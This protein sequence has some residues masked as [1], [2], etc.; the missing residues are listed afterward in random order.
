MLCKLLGDLDSNRYTHRVV[1]LIAPGPLAGRLEALGVSVDSLH[2]RKHP[3]S[4]GALARLRRITR[5]SDAD[6]VHGWMYHGNAGAWWAARGRGMRLIYTIR[7]ALTDIGREKRTT[8]ALIRFG[9]WSSRSADSVLYNSEI[10][11]QQHAR[12]GYAEAKAV[13]IPNGF[14]LDVFR[15]DAEAR[16]LVRRELE[17]PADAPVIG[18]IARYHPVK[19][20]GNFVRA[21]QTLDRGDVYYVLAGTGVDPANHELL[22]QIETAGLRERFRLLGERTDMP[23]LQAA[24]DIATSSSYTEAFP[25]AIGE[26][27][28]CGI[29]CVVTDVGDSSRLVGDTGIV[30]PRESASSLADAWRQLLER[31]PA[32][33]EEMG[34][35]GRE[36]IVARFSMG[37][38]SRRFSDVYDALLA[39]R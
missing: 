16:T 25:N 27:M 21:A 34:K 33:R 23:R 20:H 7:H 11:A 9:A 29:P 24:L 36:R 39:N 30:V 38:V 18:L 35:L 37:S 4:L 17:V 22:S 1:S 12:V 10:S 14:D 13:V 3:L 31:S 2:M 26:A 15:P 28:A 6:I 32:E 8:R 19:D 5:D